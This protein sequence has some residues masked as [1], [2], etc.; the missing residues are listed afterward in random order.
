MS[1]NINAYPF[2][3]WKEMYPDNVI[4]KYAKPK[5][6]RLL[7]NNKKNKDILQ[8][9]MKKLSKLLK[10][11]DS[12]LFFPYPKLLFHAFNLTPFDN[13]KVVIFGQDPYPNYEIINGKNVPQAMGLSFSVPIGID[14]PASLNN[15][16]QNLKKY[17]HITDIPTSGDLTC[18][19][20]QGCLLLNST[21]TV[22]FG[23]RNAHASL[24]N[25]FTDSVIKFISDNKTS[26]V[27]ILWGGNALNKLKLID[28][29]K[30]HVIISS[31]P[32]PLSFNKSLREYNSFIDTDC[33]GIV[34]QYLD[35]NGMDTINWS[36]KC[37]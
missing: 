1:I 2:L 3:S 20:V 24:W 8:D 32:S 31:H 11:N 26:I 22:E 16:Y 27:F 30:H 19:A 25:K 29:N 33:F 15:I 23:K 5:G 9:V 34:N 21:L 6:Y 37:T 4:T 10:D 18:W 28:Q 14:V 17:G 36:I 7:F 13:I 35:E 12:N